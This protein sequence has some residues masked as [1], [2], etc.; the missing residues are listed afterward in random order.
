MEQGLGL[1]SPSQTG[2]EES[3]NCHKDVSEWP[4][5]MQV[6]QH[7]WLATDQLPVRK[8]VVTNE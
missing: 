3:H 7:L 1:V 5:A 4:P 6:P 2:A 8:V